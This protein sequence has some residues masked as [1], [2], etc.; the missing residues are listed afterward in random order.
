V[1]TLSWLARLAAQR[2]VSLALVIGIVT[3]DLTIAWHDF[4]FV[5]R[6]LVDEPCHVARAR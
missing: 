3:T 2:A 6:G 5:T 1:T 4:G